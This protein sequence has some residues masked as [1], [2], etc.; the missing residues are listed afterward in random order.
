MCRQAIATRRAAK[1]FD[2]I[3]PYYASRPGGYTRVL[4]LAKN[5]LG[6]NAPRAYLGFV[7]DEEAVAETEAAAATE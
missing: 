4:R 7:R 3:G 5:R 2:E 6:D 1:F